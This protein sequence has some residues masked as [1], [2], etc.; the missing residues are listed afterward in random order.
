MENTKLSSGQIVK[1][2]LSLNSDGYDYIIPDEG[3]FFIGDYVYV[4]FR[5]KQEVGATVLRLACLIL[6]LILYCLLFQ[7]K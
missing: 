3:E 2:L 1:V 4:P 6:L 5:L 7:I